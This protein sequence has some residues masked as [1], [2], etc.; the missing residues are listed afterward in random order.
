MSTEELMALRNR[1][2]AAKANKQEIAAADAYLATLEALV[3]VPFTG[4][5]GSVQHLLVL[6]TAA[7]AGEEAPQPQVTPIPVE[8]PPV[9]EPTPTPQEPPPPSPLP[10]AEAP[11]PEQ[12]SESEPPPVK[13]KPV[14]K[15]RPGKQRKAQTD[16]APSDS[17]DPTD[18]D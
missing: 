4:R 7:L 11:S 9:A 16:D 13:R 15:P 17:S 3:S 14:P 8:A 6:V 12:E 5:R 10:A 2:I 1:L 18:N